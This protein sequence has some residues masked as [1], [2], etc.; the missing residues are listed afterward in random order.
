[1]LVKKTYIS[2]SKIPNAGLGL[3]AGEKILKGE[4][5]WVNHP[6]SEKVYQPDEWDALPKEFKNSI[7][8]Y[9]YKSDGLYRINIDNSRHFNHSVTSSV[10]MD[11]DGN[12]VAVSDLCIGDE[13]TCDYSLFYDSDWLS[14]TLT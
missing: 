2:K 13:I 12:N 4:K 3:F 6:C 7:E 10:I 9:V 14:K 1:M 8:M 5:V 11:D